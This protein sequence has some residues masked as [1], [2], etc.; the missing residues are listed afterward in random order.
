M[1]R[2]KRAPPPS[3]A[4]LRRRATSFAET[5]TTAIVATVMAVPSPITKVA[6]MPAQN[7]PC[8]S[9]NTST[10]MAPE[11]GLSPTAKIAAS[12]RRH[13]PDGRLRSVGMAAVL[14]MYMI[15]AEGLVMAV[16]AVG[17]MLV[18]EV[19]HMVAALVAVQG[20]VRCHGEG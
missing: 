13:P 18:I 5:A 16:V 8:A 19:M 3:L 2:M 14:V 12:P 20:R 4:L 10:R 1:P 11:Q 6:A 9:A 17:V 7:R 15:P